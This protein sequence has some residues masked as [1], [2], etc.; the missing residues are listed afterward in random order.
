MYT[1]MHVQAHIYPYVDIISISTSPMSVPVC[2]ECIGRSTH[3][4]TYIQVQAGKCTHLSI[5]VAS[6]SCTSHRHSGSRGLPLAKIWSFEELRETG[7]PVSHPPPSKLP[8]T[9]LRKKITNVKHLR[10]LMD[11]SKNLRIPWICLSCQPCRHRCFFFLTPFLPR[12]SPSE[13]YKCISSSHVW[14][15]TDCICSLSVPLGTHLTPQTAYQSISPKQ[16]QSSP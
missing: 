6:L 5:G 7:I 16:I 11:L 1:H 10:S 9:T 12:S 8:F 4:L 13:P 3:W 2:T 15:C 14:Q